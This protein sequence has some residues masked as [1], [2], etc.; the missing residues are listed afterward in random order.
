MKKF[1][2]VLLTLIPT[3]VCV[4]GAYPVYPPET[5]LAYTTQSITLI[6]PSVSP[7]SYCPSCRP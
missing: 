1:R 5:G 4:A 6:T 2:A 3:L 7:S